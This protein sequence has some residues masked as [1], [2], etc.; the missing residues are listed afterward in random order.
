MLRRAKSSRR[1][2][3]EAKRAVRVMLCGAALVVPSVAQA[4]DL[5]GAVVDEN[6]G[7]ALRG[8]V[9]RLVGEDGRT[10]A[11]TTTDRDGRY[12]LRGL[13]AGRYELKVD[14]LGYAADT[15]TVEVPEQGELR[16]DFAL[17]QAGDARG[18][19]EEVIVTGYA[20]GQS[21]ALNQQRASDLVSSVLSADDLGKFPDNNIAESLARLPG[22][23]V[24]RD[25]QTGEGALVTVRGLDASLNSFSVNGVRVA[26]SD[27]ASRA[28]ALNVLPPTG[29]QTVTVSK[30]LTPD[31][32]GDAIG[33]AVNFI[34][35]TAFDFG[36][37]TASLSYRYLYNDRE[38]D[39]GNLIAADFARLFGPAQRW[40]LYLTAYHS[41]QDTTG[42]ESENEGDWEPYRWRRNGQVPVDARSYQLQGLGLDVFE[43]EIERFG[44]NFSLDYQGEGG[45]RYYLRGQYAHYENPETHS[46]VDVRNR[47]APA[48]LEQVDKDNASLPQPNDVVVSVAPDGTRTYAYTTAQIVDHDGDGVITDRDGIEEFENGSTDR[49][50]SLI[51]GSGVWDPQEFF[52]ARGGEIEDVESTLASINVGGEQPFGR[53]LADFNLAYSFGET[54]NPRYY[55]LA[56]ESEAAGPFAQQGVFFTYPDPRF[57]HWT[58]PPAANAAIYD[59][60]LLAFDGAEVSSNSSEDS[61]TIVQMN[62]RRAFGQG[63]WLDEA[64]AGIKLTQ[65]RREKD[66]Q[67]IFDG[68]VPCPTLADCPEL[69]AR[70]ENAFLDGEYSGNDAFGPVFNRGALIALLDAQGTSEF[71]A[72][73][74]NE[75]DSEATEDIYAA[76]VMGSRRFDALELIG[77]VRVEMTELENT[78][79]QAEDEVADSRFVKEDADAVHVLP[80]IHLNYRPDPRQVWRAALW[81]SIARPDFELV[82]SGR[83]VE[84]DA[85]GEIISISQGNPDLESA[86]AVNLDL[87]YEFYPGGVS[88]LSLN[89]FYKDIRNFIFKENANSSELN[90]NGVEISQPKNGEEAQIYGFEV[91]T[92]QQLIWLPQ[93]WSGTGFALNFTYQKSEADTGI[94]YRGGDKIPFINAPERQAN[95]SLFWQYAG[96]ET[97]LAYNYNGKYIEDLRNNAVDKWI[98][99][100]ERLDYQARYTFS[101]GF[102]RGL[103]LIFEAQNLADSHVYW[104]TRGSGNGF[105]KDYVETGRTFF[106]TTSYRFRP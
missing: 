76:Y 14:F 101:R 24:V 51:G 85:S 79:W 19:V 42:Q 18:G 11:Q 30:T 49:L 98:Q 45:A 53:W 75:N 55:D 65:S 91:G 72:N 103:S 77:G 33:G 57:P 47:R 37:R 23:S 7:G 99:P 78:V 41:D 2:G 93:P 43:D 88:L 17:A 58:L 26:Q 73:D 95:M 97:Q 22:I 20:Y 83:S 87:G 102:A 39:T 66:E 44:G 1:F 8:A 54:E 36:E 52:V 82:T 12:T 81:T 50:Y 34:T 96:F 67:Q 68:E 38:D 10:R 32:D 59:N 100:F 3:V 70:F 15:R 69:I 31:L 90:V 4:G 80:S 60:S 25:Q 84:R 104:A 9:V 40:G 71:D 105:Q 92:V 35:P 13:S 6:R 89:L 27:P 94:D 56:F 29:I 16:A 46:Y 62:L 106:V 5:A 48:R 64:R 86:E 74:Q 21:R 28:L 63:A 61:K